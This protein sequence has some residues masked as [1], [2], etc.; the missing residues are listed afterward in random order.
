MS[1]MTMPFLGRGTLP[2][3][4]ATPSMVN[5]MGMCSAR[6]PVAILL[7]ATAVLCSPAGVC[8]LD[9][10]VAPAPADHR[11]HACC[12][13]GDGAFLTAHDGSCCSEPRTGFLNIAR[14][15]LHRQALPAILD[16]ADPWTQKVFVTGHVALDRR[17]P[18]VLRI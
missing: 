12:N 18:L 9:A 5:F 4:R 16:V 15:T 6:Q 2:V 14:F 8:A 13:P 3:C 11:A 1:A 17:V 7:L 10:A